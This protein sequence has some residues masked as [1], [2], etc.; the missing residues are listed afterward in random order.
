MPFLVGSEDVDD[1]APELEEL[2][3]PATPIAT[4]AK[5]ST[6]NLRGRPPVRASDDLLNM[7]PPWWCGSQSRANASERAPTLPAMV[8]ASSSLDV[9]PPKSF[10]RKDRA[11][12]GVSP[13][14]A[15]SPSLCTDLRARP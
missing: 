12:P 11:R 4:R 15:H 10:H 9:P 13:A 1:V 7:R 14:E 6:S 3:Q 5:P 2:P 8:D